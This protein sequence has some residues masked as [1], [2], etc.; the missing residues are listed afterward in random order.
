MSATE[1]LPT[2][3]KGRLTLF[4]AVLA[5]ATAIVA[6]LVITAGADRKAQPSIAGGYDVSGPAMARR[7]RASSH[8]P[9]VEREAD[10]V[11]AARQAQLVLDVGAMRLDRAEAD[12]Q[13]PGDLGVGVAERGE[14]QDVGLAGREVL[15]RGVSAAPVST[16]T[17]SAGSR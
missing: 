12:V 15:D 9:V 14:A 1:P 2:P 6:Y 7:R 11:G 13:H 5:A 16:P 17:P 3:P 4:Y 10:E 8:E